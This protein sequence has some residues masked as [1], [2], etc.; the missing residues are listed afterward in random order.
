MDSSNFNH[1]DA[2]YFYSESDHIQLNKKLGVDDLFADAINSLFAQGRIKQSTQVRMMQELYEPLKQAV[3]EGWG[4]V[5]AIEYNTPNY[6]F[7]KQLKTNTAV[8]AAFKNHSRMKDMA[9]LLIDDNGNKRSK[10]DFIAEALKANNKYK[11]QHLSV[12]YDAAVKQARSAAQ[13]KK[14]LET[15]HLFPNIKY[16]PSTSANK[17]ELHIKYYGLTLPIEHKLWDTILPIKVWGCKCWWTVTDDAVTKIP[18]SFEAL[19]PA[20]GLGV[21]A[22]K[23]GQVFDLNESSYAQGISSKTK[24]RLKNDAVKMVNET[25]AMDAPYFD[26]H[27][28][29][30]TRTKIEAHP[31]GINDSDFDTNLDKAKKL[32]KSFELERITLIPNVPNEKPELK[33][34]LQAKFGKE[35]TCDYYIK[36]KFYD[37]K[38][39]GQDSITDKAFKEKFSKTK[40][41]GGDGIVLYISNPSYISEER[42]YRNINSKY[43]DSGYE[44][45]ECYLFYNKKWQHFGNKKEWIRFYESYKS[46]NPD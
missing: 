44:N 23:T 20:D 13:Y 34:V 38:E 4:K 31:Y 40:Q 30:K 22:G 15:K 16:M 17:R 29:K 39:D 27:T 19:P 43:L 8:F 6:E 28:D 21:H 32:A 2:S 35:T 12:E 42:M 18:E 10:P 33:K 7:L 5:N 14:A 25:E 11:V 1:N 45:F 24:A 37:L 9:A 26:I 46:Q 41:Q 3:E 36:G